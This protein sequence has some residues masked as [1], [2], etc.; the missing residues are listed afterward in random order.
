MATIINYAGWV[1][2]DDAGGK[3]KFR[4]EIECETEKD[5]PEFPIS[6]VG[7]PVKITV[8]RDQSKT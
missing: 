2:D 7:E 1:L 3:Q 5:V 6:W 8:V 4:I